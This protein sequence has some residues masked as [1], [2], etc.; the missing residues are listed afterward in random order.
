MFL[1]EDV[2][3]RFDTSNVEVDRLLLMGKNGK[4]NERAKTYSYLKDSN[5]EDKKAKGTKKLFHKRKLKFKGYKICLKESRMENIINY[6]EKKETDVDCL[7][8]DN[9]EFLKIRLILKTH[10]TFKSERHNIFTEEIN[11]IALSS[12]YDKRMQSVDSI[13]RYAYGM[14]KDLYARKKK[15]NTL[16]S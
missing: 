11:K 8:E 3:T 7:K 1:T 14:S 15:L 5:D 10:K 4:K 12:N 13:E 6:L 9:K 2:E 16:V